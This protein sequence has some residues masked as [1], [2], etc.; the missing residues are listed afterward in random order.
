MLGRAQ[1]IENLEKQIKAQVL[2][3]DEART[4]WCGPKPP[5]PMPRN[6]WWPCAARPVS[7]SRTHALQVETLRLTQM[8]EQARLRSAQ[9]E[10]DLAE[11]DAQLEK[12]CKSGVSPPGSL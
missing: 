4:A 10:G 3:S 12:T 9:I 7:Q 8:A 2:I 5:M 6:G 1:E 11:V